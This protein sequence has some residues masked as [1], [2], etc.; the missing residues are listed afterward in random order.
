[1]NLTRIEDREEDHKDS[2]PDKNT[3]A[4]RDKDHRDTMCTQN[5][6][7]LGANA[8]RDGDHRDLCVFKNTC[9]LSTKNTDTLCE[10]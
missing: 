8:M 5:Y 2:V 7:Y 4:M 1:M 6:T 3:C 10:H 9:P